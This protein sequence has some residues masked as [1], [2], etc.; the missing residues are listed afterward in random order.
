MALAAAGL[1]CEKGLSVTDAQS[2]RKSYPGF[3]RDFIKLGGFAHVLD[4]G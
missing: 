1:R 2:I 4:L 3:F